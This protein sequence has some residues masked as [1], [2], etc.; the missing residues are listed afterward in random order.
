MTHSVVVLGAGYGG[1]ATI[2][3]L[4][5][6]NADFKLTWI[7]KAPY[8]FVRHESHRLIRRPAAESALTVPIESIAAPNTRFVQATVTRV[9]AET[10]SVDLEDGRSIQYDFLVYA[11]G[12]EP[13]D[14]GIPG[15]DEHALTLN[16]LRD[17]L[18][19]HEAVIEATAGRAPNDPARVVV[20]G[21][22]LSG[23][24]VAGELAS[25]AADRELPL[26]I[27]QVEAKNRILPE[28]AP[29]L[30]RRVQRLLSDRGIDV[31]TGSPVTRVTDKSVEVEEEGTLPADVIVWTGG[32]TGPTVLTDG[33]LDGMAGR[34]RTNAWLQT[35]DPRVFALGDAAIV[36]SAGEPIPPTAQAAWQAAVVVATNITRSIQEGPLKRFGFESRGTLLSVGEAAIAHDV[37]HSPLRTITGVPAHLLKKGVAARWIAGISSWRR[38]LDA[39]PYL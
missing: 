28:D 5:T 16:G 32:I 17:A 9:N 36:D 26:R 31:I 24:Q 10:R 20:A 38:A 33:G 2:D 1:A 21:A 6:Q 7:S 14:Y 8:H 39:W 22:G 37:I 4:Q 35:S 11:M 12:S 25:L 13:A 23:V 18:A 19:I 3:R 29:D 27:R 15:I 34:L 30:S